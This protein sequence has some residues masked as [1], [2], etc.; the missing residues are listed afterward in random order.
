M[1]TWGKLMIGVDRSEPKTPPLVIVKVPPDRSSI[2]SLPSRARFAM[3]TMSRAIWSIP[4]R[5]ASLIF[6]TTSPASD[7][8]AIPMFT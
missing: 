6:G 2:V 3:S 8:T 5:S 7:A 4:F 1:P